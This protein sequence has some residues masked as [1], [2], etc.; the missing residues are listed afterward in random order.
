MPPHASTT[1]KGSGEY[2]SNK[3]L[4]RKDKERATI[5]K[6]RI[7]FVFS[8]PFQLLS[9]LLIQ[10]PIKNIFTIITDSEMDRLMSQ[11]CDDYIF[12]LFFC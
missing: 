3:E 12:P 10:K 9:V 1:S 7:V 6:M 4:A 2:K 5:E 8:F 11:K